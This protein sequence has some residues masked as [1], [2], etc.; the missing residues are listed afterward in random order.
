MSE[1]QALYIARRCL[2]AKRPITAV[3]RALF[4]ERIKGLV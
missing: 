3:A 4:A 2:A 1:K